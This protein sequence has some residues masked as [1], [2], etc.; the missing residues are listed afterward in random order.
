MAIAPTRRFLDASTTTPV[1]TTLARILVIH[2]RR[3]P[4]HLRPWS[5]VPHMPAIRLGNGTRFTT[6]ARRSV[7]RLAPPRNET[8]CMFAELE[9]LT[10]GIRAPGG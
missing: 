1:D 8:T 2:D 3:L 10:H 4:R 9:R 7:S 5:V 6:R